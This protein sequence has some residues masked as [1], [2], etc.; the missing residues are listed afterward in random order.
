MRAYEDAEEDEEKNKMD[1]KRD[2]NGNG[3]RDIK[4]ISRK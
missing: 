3:E 2:E 1:D 4:N